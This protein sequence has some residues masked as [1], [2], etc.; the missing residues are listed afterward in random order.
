MSLTLFQPATTLGQKP[1]ARLKTITQHPP[2][3]ADYEQIVAYWTTET[4]WASEL[5]LR[6]NQPAK[7]LTVTPVLRLV[8]GSETPLTAVTVKPQEVTSI[9]LVTAVG[10]TAP[11]LIGSYGSLVPRYHALAQA[12][13]YAALMIRN[14][15]H[16]FAFHID[17]MAE[18][19]SDQAGARE[20][21]WWLP[22]N[23]TSDYLILTNQGQNAIPVDLSLYDATGKESKQ[24]RSQTWKV[25]GYLVRTNSLTISDTGLTYT[26]QGPN[27]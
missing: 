2:D 18:T 1:P 14:I 10:T 7:D 12:N 23:T 8:D 5:Q 22:K 21:I 17:A 20:G 24:S 25:G 15:G 6:N 3:P 9:D 4:G 13:L 19:Q 26:N 16:P 27:Q 11:Q